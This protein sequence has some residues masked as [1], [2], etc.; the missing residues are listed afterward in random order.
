MMP[1]SLTLVRHGESEGNLSRT[2]Y[3]LGRP[4]PNEE[5]LMK[6]HTSDRR[7]TPTGIEQAKAAG[8]WLKENWHGATEPGA[9]R[10]YVSPYIRAIETAG[11]LGFGEDWRL[12][13]RLMERNWGELDLLTLEE[14]SRRFGEKAEED[15]EQA[16]FW[17]PADG[18]TLQDVFQRTRDM[19]NT[20]HRECEDKDVLIVCHG[21]VM[22]VWRMILEYWTPRE[23]VSQTKNRDLQT[24]NLNCR[25]IQ[26]TR[27]QVERPKGYLPLSR[28]LEWVRFVNPMA[29][30][31]PQ[32]NRDWRPIKRR[33]FS[34][35]ELLEYVSTFPRFLEG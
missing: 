19:M 20:L 33:L 13:A 32:T 9:F 6:V 31:D 27:H 5:K 35:E 16:F 24:R 11:H 15:I 18:E 25:I 26:Y 10:L 14:R 1:R 4:H 3:D 12:D 22:R 23:L 34:H 28:R 30:E 2:L 7:L 29:P 17:R 8:A 21:E